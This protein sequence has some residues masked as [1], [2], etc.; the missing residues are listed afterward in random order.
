M[1]FGAFLSPSNAALEDPDSSPMGD[2]FER[3]ERVFF[4]VRS[5]PFLLVVGT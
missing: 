4:Y 2:V 5:P 3:L 1:G